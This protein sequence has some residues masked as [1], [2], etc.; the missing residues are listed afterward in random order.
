MLAVSR[1]I[2]PNKLFF[3]AI[4]ALTLCSLA[5]PQSCAAQNS[6]SPSTEASAQTPATPEPVAPPT[7]ENAEPS[8]MFPHSQTARWWVSGQQNTIFQAHPAFHA[9]YSGP[10]SLQPQSQQAT[11]YVETLYLGYQVWRGAEALLDIESA[12]GKGLSG[13][14]GLAGFTNLDV[15]RRSGSAAPYVARVEFHQT[16]RLSKE[17]VDADRGPLSL[18]TSVPT[19]RLELRYGK[20]STADFFDVN[21]VGSDSH[22]QFMNWTVDN[23]GAYDYPADTHGYTY[24]FEAEYQSTSWA[25]RFGDM[26]MPKVANSLD[27]DWDLRRARSENY[28]LELRPTLLKD[29]KTVVRL[30]AYEN[31]ANMGD[32][33]AAVARYKAGLDPRPIIENTRRQGTVKYGFGI[34]AEQELPR[35]IR[36][37]LRLGWDEGQHE[38]FA[39][40]EVNSTAA[41]GADWAGSHWHRK[42]DKVGV[43]VVSNGIS[44]AHQ[45]Y[46][47]DG[48]LG[49]LL[50]DNPSYP[51]GA[52]A[53]G[54]LNYGRENIIESY[55]TLHVWRG[56]YFAGDVQ[57]IW[58][59]GYNRD[60][61]PVLV[62]SARLHIEF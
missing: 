8:A 43:A 20:L 48:G 29:H 15:V 14:L 4:F 45:A 40:T 41:A 33:E 28:E 26:L 51:A 3:T 12:G 37:F 1:F 56:L 57:H 18:A 60:R 42:L 47:R 10:N 62:P 9:A 13:T 50:G 55:Y 31:H 53:S 34:N 38:S 24:G 35:D 27:L 59:P 58:N 7:E 39:Y 17:N 52:P 21:G 23:N 46:L 30:L 2:M 25:F 16:F 32:Y 61:G 5:R 36:V 11:S 19:R 44:A 49:F 54:A 6:A 22:L